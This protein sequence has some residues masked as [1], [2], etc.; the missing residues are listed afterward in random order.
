MYPEHR[1]QAVMVN[2]RLGAEQIMMTWRSSFKTEANAKPFRQIAILMDFF[3]RIE[4]LFEAIKPKENL[5]AFNRL[6]KLSLK[7]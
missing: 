7:D 4:H 2:L 5:L 3:S 6:Q 1:T